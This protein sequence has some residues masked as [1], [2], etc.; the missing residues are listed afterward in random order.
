M[1]AISGT[2]IASGLNYPYGMAVTTD[3]NIPFGESNPLIP[4]GIDGGPST[5]S[6]SS[7]TPLRSGTY[8]T[9][10]QL[11]GGFS[12]P[13]QSVSVLNMSQGQGLVVDSGA[14][15]GRTIANAADAQIGQIQFTYSGS[16]QT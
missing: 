9:P 10:N 6:V 2:T 15:S 8:G 5:G 16:Y 12:G 14:S 13:A 3:G 11:A 1:G 4:S 7:I